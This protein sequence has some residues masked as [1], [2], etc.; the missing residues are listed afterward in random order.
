MTRRAVCYSSRITSHG[1]STTNPHRHRRLVLQRLGGNLLSARNAPPETTS[2]GI[3]GAVLRHGGNQ[4]FVLW[5]Y[6]ARTGQAVG[7]QSAGGESEFRVHGE[8]ASLV[9]P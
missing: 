8:A 2:A 4:H 6:Q 9:Y 3:L 7:A 1:R 5:P